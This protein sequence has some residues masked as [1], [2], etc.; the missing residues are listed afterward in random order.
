MPDISYEHE[1]RSDVQNHNGSPLLV[2]T[3]GPS[4]LP[5]SVYDS[6]PLQL[7]ETVHIRVV[8]IHTS[9]VEDFSSRI[10]CEFSVVV[11]VDKGDR[12]NVIDISPRPTRIQH[13]A[14]SYTWDDA[15]ADCIIELNGQPFHVRRNLL[16]FLDRARKADF[17]WY[18]WIDTLYID[19]STIRE[20][21]HQ[22]ALMGKIYSQEREVL[23][24]LG[25]VPVGVEQALNKSPSEW[26]ADQDPAL[27][28]SE[29]V[30]GAKAFCA[31][32]YWTRAWIV[33]EYVLAKKILIWCGHFRMTDEALSWLLRGIWPG[34]LRVGMKR[35]AM[36]IIN[37]GEEWLCRT[38]RLD[39]G[40]G[41]AG[42]VELEI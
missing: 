3:D 13:T 12:Y 38:N 30:D 36:R 21:N 35:T 15:P 2:P 34:G 33:Q 9:I 18:L 4:A 17:V 7:G 20:R 10:L 27:V 5:R 25:H 6:V 19:Q 22:V 11:D 23:L 14:L 28:E 31:L 29:Y 32:G 24:W 40:D 8:Y 37:F 41:S 26:Y 42:L 39:S 1:L 16:D